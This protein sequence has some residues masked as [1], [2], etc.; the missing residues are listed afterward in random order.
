MVDVI[1]ARATNAAVVEDEAARFD[2]I[3][4][5]A[6]SGG[7][8]HHG[9][10]VLRDVGFE[11]DEA[12]DRSRGGGKR[13]TRETELYPPVKSFLERLGFEVKAE[14]GGCDVF[15][16]RGEETPVIV[17]LKRRFT[18]ELVLQGVD[19][20]AV[21]DLV[22]LATERP[23]RNARGPS[24]LSGDVRK[25]CRR[26]GLGLMSVEPKSGLVEV[27]LD[28]V[29]YTPRRD[30]KRAGRLLGEFA[31]RVGDH[32]VGGSTRTPIVTAYR[33]DALRCARL[34][35]DGPRTL[36][37]L[38]AAGA[39]ADVAHILQRDVYG[40]FRRTGRG[41]YALSEAGR[42]ALDRFAHVPGDGA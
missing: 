41:V 20:L 9:A 31:R 42:A 25:L 17:E 34:V 18:L 28:P 16:V 37:E 24:L 38:R 27:V 8:P 4:R 26:L 23:G 10:G 39:P 2:E 6:E 40:W 30:K 22:Y 19:R 3:H 32:N 14:V 13:V 15:A 21:S 1:H 12:H 11:E 29:P 36:A 35:L 5:H 7:E 33:Q